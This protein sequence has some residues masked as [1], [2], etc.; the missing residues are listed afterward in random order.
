[1][2]KI[3]LGII[4]ILFSVAIFSQEPITTVVPTE[5]LLKKSTQH[6]FSISPNGKYFAEVIDT[7]S[8]SD[9]IIVDI[10]NYL[11]L[12]KI[13][14]GNISI[15]RVYWLTNNRLLYESL[16]AIYAIDID[17]SNPM[18]IVDRVNV[19]TFDWGKLY[20]NISFNRLVGLMPGKDHQILIET[21]DYNMYASIKEVNIFTGQTYT[22]MNGGE[23]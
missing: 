15:D 17:G 16:G 14:M 19:V 5:I 8:A 20:K 1:M 18:Q 13:P 6:N 22:V 21:L 10:D 12:H 9:L 11:L 7:R 2:K 23:V 4:C 3:T